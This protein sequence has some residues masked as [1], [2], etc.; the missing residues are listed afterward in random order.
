ML[1]YNN[2]EGRKSFMK[3]I[4]FV[5]IILMMFVISGK[6]FAEIDQQLILNDMQMQD[7]INSI[8]FKILNA[9]KIDK[10]MV[11][12]YDD[13]NKES[14]LKEPGL[15]SRQVVV[16]KDSI[17]F[18]DN[19]EE[20]AAFLA[21]EICKTAESYTGFWKGIV[22][23]AQ[24]KVAPKKYELLFDKRAVDFMVNAGYNPLALITFINKSFVQ[25][26]YDMI[27]NHNLTSKRL[28]NIYEYIY[29][30]YPYF[31]VNNEYI[32]NEYYQNFLLTSI[33]NRKKLQQKINTGSKE[34]IKYE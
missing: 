28:A 27:S 22:G 18:A 9:N 3:K 34:R 7:K 4:L 6:A 2:Y 10:R 23:S 13:K 25:K 29:F 17:N 5:I 26:R 11:F 19:E 14:I 20:I 32:N 31:L 1:V 21:R 16:Y 24:V 15:T 30:N 33:E 8:G 12:V